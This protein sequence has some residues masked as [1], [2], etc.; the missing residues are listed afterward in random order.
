MG[1]DYIVREFEGS[2]RN[3]GHR[4]EHQHTARSGRRSGFAARSGPRWPAPPTGSEVVAWSIGGVS[5]LTRAATGTYIFGL[6]PVV[7]AVL[8]SALLMW[9]VSLAT[10]RPSP[11]TVERY[12]RR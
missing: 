11:A 10:P 4:P 6:L 9:I 12:F 3:T 5:I 2:L 8:G 7:T 1:R